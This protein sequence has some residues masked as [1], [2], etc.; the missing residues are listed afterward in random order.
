[1]RALARRRRLIRGR[2]RQRQRRLLVCDRATSL[3]RSLPRHARH[4]RPGSNADKITSRSPHPSRRRNHPPPH[5][6]SAQR[7]RGLLLPACTAPAPRLAPSTG[8]RERMAGD[9]V[10]GRPSRLAAASGR[11][12]HGRARHAGRCSP[13]GAEPPRQRRPRPSDRPGSSPRGGT[14]AGAPLAHLTPP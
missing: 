9:V 6:P 8:C 11:P 5:G 13:A 10:E 12:G 1:M 4:G 14:G 7:R 3:A 2:R